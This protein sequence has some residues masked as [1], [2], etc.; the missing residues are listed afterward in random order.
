MPR[1][2]EPGQEFDI[3]M[4][5][6]HGPRVF[7]FRSVSVRQTMELRK[8]IAV[9]AI[10]GIA[11]FL[12]ETLTGWENVKDADGNAVEFAADK[13]LDVVSESGLCDLY[14]GFSL[15]GEDKKKSE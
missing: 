9:D 11:E 8:K 5:S 4:E 6:Q 10:N 2:L 12:Q 1:C 7:K 14:R 3:E 15:S 13:L